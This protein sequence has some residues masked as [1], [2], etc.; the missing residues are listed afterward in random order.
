MSRGRP[1]WSAADD[2][3]LTDLHGD[4]VSQHEAARQMDRSRS[5][6]YRASARLGLTWDRTAT[7]AAVAAK[8]VDNDATRK[9]L[10]GALLAEAQTAL[11]RK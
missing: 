2:Q 9:A 6:I 10:E 8:A 11:T 3:Q 7:Q 4:G 1:Q 5:T